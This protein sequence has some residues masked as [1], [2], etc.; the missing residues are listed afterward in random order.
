MRRCEWIVSSPSKRSS[1]CLP[2]A[3]TARTA[4]PSSRSRPAIAGE[5]RMRRREALGHPPLEQR[6]DPVGGVV[7]GVALGHF[8]EGTLGACEPISPASSGTSTSCPGT[9]RSTPPTR[10]RRAPCAASPRRSSGP[11]TPSRSPR[12]SHGAARTRSR[13]CRAAAAPAGP[14]A[15]C[16]AGPGVVLALE[17]LDRVRCARPAAVADARRGRRD[18]GDRRSASRARTASTTRPTRVPPRARRSAATSRRTRAGRTA[19][20]TA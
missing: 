1:R 7:D 11:A 4:R 20:S 12:S 14:A 18:D 2:I 3:S 15:R 9:M 5:A 17:R 16:R 8:P 19:S 13:S 6:P 10:P